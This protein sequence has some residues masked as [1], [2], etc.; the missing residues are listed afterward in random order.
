MPKLAIPETGRIECVIQVKPNNSY[1]MRKIKF[2]VDTG[3]D[4]C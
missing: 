4:L 1:L 2:K 3:A